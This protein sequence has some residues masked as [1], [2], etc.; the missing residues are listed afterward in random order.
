MDL[1]AVWS[2]PSLQLGSKCTMGTLMTQVDHELFMTLKDIFV[3]L[4]CSLV[5]SQGLEQCLAHDRPA[6]TLALVNE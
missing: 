3:Y 5:Y 4:L 1:A 2:F 6:V